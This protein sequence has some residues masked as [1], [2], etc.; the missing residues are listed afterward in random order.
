[1]A[2]QAAMVTEATVK[3]DSRIIEILNKH[4]KV[5]DEAIKDAGYKAYA[6]LAVE[7]G[8]AIA[9]M[10]LAIR[11]PDTGRTYRGFCDFTYQLNTNVF[12]EKN[13]SVLMPLIHMALNT[14]RDGVFMAVERQQRNEYSGADTLI[15]SS[16][17]AVLEIFPVI[18]YLVGG[19]VL[20]VEVS[21]QLKLDLAPFFV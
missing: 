13:A 18:A 11:N 9:N 10:F 17:A 4:F 8:V 15:A 20:M 16:R 19:P 5:S 21:A 14:F 6:G 3:L 7:V 2:Q 1:M 12:W